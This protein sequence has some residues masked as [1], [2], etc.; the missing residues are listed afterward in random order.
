VWILRGQGASQ[1]A[2]AR[3]A[4][5]NVKTIAELENSVLTR[6]RPETEQDILALTIGQVR[7]FEKHG[8]WGRTEPAAPVLQLVDEM[9]AL[10]WPKAWIAR[11]IGQQRA[12]QLGR[13]HDTVSVANASKIRQLRQSVG[14]MTP[15]RIWRQEL[16]PLAEILAAREKRLSSGQRQQAN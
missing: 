11:E 7:E 14:Y 10:G 5:L 3:A 2:I 9:V 15:P 16:P 12:L 4:D 8:R 1:K 6:I 13:N